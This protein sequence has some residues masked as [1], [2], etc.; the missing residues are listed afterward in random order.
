VHAKASVE[1]FKVGV[2]A[3]DLAMSMLLWDTFKALNHVPNSAL[4]VS[5]CLDYFQVEE[6]TFLKYLYGFD[7]T[8]DI[9]FL[10]DQDSGSFLI[11]VD[12][13]DLACFLEPWIVRGSQ[14]LN[15]TCVV[16]SEFETSLR[17]QLIQLNL[18]G[19]VQLQKLI[20]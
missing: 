17:S 15:N 4:K 18:A 2:S 9:F 12:H 1:V 3:A 7:L 6:G 11:W 13:F 8:P 16:V 5:F 14:R 20:F 10:L 19:L